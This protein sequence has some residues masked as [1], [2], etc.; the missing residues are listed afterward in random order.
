MS[1]GNG[2]FSVRKRTSRAARA[3]TSASPELEG[4]RHRFVDVAGLRMHVVQAGEG[5]P[6]LLLH[7]FPQHWWEWRKVIPQLAEHYRVVCPDLRGAGWTEAPKGGYDVDQMLADVLGLLDAL[8]LDRVRVIGHDFGGILAYQLCLRHPTRV[9]RYLALSTPPPYL[10][11]EPRWLTV[12]WRL[13]FQPV[14]AA[15]V[16]GPFLLS[17]GRQRVV[18]FMFVR[19]KSDQPEDHDAWSA[20]DVELFLFPLREPEHARAGSATYRRLILPELVRFINGAYRGT[21]LTTPTLVLIGAADPALRPE[22]ISGYEPYVDDL[23]VEFVEGA[24][25][26]IADERPDLVVERALEFFALE[27]PR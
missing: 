22:F 20:H 9:V 21:R 5:E 4:A 10:S 12:M 18:R 19:F 15:P 2:G 8:E 1:P 25:H 23:E 13:W 16:V 26:F 7:G 27:S 17:R 14:I 11:F 3:L 24:S 6:V